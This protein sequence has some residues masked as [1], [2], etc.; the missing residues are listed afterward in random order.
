MYQL[1]TSVSATETVSNSNN[2]DTTNKGMFFTAWK[3]GGSHQEQCRMTPLITQPLS[4]LGCKQLVLAQAP[5]TL[6][7]LEG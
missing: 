7:L 6:G 4:I 2:T 3:A 5:S 1:S